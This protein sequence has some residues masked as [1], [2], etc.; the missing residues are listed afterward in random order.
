MSRLKYL[1]M[2]L[3]VRSKGLTL[4]D[5]TVHEA[6]LRL[7]CLIPASPSASCLSSCPPPPPAPIPRERPV[8][9]T[10]PEVGAPSESTSPT[11]REQW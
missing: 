7:W 1:S 5:P 11:N 8:Q 6:L 2:L 9:R 10:Y 4:L 3:Q